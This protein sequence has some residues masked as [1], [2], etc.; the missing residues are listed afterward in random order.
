MESYPRSLR[1][2]DRLQTHSLLPNPNVTIPESAF[3][4]SDIQVLSNVLSSQECETI[5]SNIAE[6]MWHEPEGYHKTKR[7]ANRACILDSALAGTLWERLQ[8]F[9]SYEGKRPYGFMTQGTWK[10]LRI[11]ECCRISRYIGPSVGFTVHADAQ[12]CSSFNEKSI[13]SIIIYLSDDCIG[14]ETEFFP[15]NKLA[16]DLSFDETLYLNFGTPS[17]SSSICVKPV[18]GTAV[19]FPHTL[20]H[21]GVN[22]KEG[23]K[24]VLRTDLIFERVSCDETNF[25]MSEYTLAAA[26]HMNAERLELR[27]DGINASKLYEKSLTTRMAQDVD[28]H[29]SSNLIIGRV[30]AI[31]SL[32]EISIL[33]YLHEFEYDIFASVCR[34]FRVYANPFE[35]KYSYPQDDE[36]V[37][38]AQFYEQHTQACL[39]VTAMMHLVNYETDPRE[40]YYVAHFNRETGHVL[41]V[42][43]DRLYNAAFRGIPCT[44]ELYRIPSSPTITPQAQ[45]KTSEYK[46][47]YNEQE[48]L[49]NR[50]MKGPCSVLDTVTPRL[51]HIHELTPMFHVFNY[52]VDAY[53]PAKVE[54]VQYHCHETCVNRFHCTFHGCDPINV[55]HSRETIHQ[56][57]THALIFDFAN[58][59]FKITPTALCNKDNERCY[60]VD[61]PHR[62]FNH[63]SCEGFDETLYT[64]T[65]IT[66]IEKVTQ[67]LSA[68]HICEQRNRNWETWENRIIHTVR[69]ISMRAL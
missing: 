34:L 35:P 47:S 37:Y 28:P 19:I 62:G 15:S 60:R 45:C 20:F 3:V 64:Q 13:Y 59:E 38:E 55:T 43:K 51:S 1:T 17:S 23:T 46:P 32:W 24:L 14:G 33:S 44:G 22:V 39:R 67:S 26:H 11:N 7:D 48:E 30:L 52:P 57:V 49:H 16:S 63:A 61:F 10:P 6:D 27:G 53:E 66:K 54:M 12:F 5:L 68:M 9:C 42:K 58:Y 18:T 8:P 41:H 29:L 31:R 4:D 25:L 21:Q 56:S 50:R 65:H 40:H 2:I 36:C 69:Y